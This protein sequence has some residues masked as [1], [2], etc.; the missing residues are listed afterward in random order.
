LGSL[1]TRSG[2]DGSRHAK[3]SRPRHARGDASR[4]ALRGHG[5]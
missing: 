4:G 1:D 5:R 3:A 2:S